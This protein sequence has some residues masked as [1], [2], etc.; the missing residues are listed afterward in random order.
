M[1]W[2]CITASFWLL[3]EIST[4]EEARLRN[5]HTCI[6]G[7][8]SISVRRV[9]TSFGFFLLIENTHQ[10]VDRLRERER[11]RERESEC[12]QQTGCLAALKEK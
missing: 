11:E 12:H 4:W 6:S 7:S 2:F 3:N 1:I 5:E 8:T 10:C 9:K